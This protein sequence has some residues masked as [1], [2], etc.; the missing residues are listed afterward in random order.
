MAAADT[1]NTYDTNE[2]NSGKSLKQTRV[3]EIERAAE[4]LLALAAAF[5]QAVRGREKESEEI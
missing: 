2:G 1:R 5:P 4:A 3:G